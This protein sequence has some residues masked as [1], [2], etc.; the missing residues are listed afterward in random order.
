MT[1]GGMF[2]RNRVLIMTLF[3]SLV[4]SVF[5][6]AVAVNGPLEDLGVVMVGHQVMSQERRKAN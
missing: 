4:V 6:G 1:M 5:I 2:A 3:R